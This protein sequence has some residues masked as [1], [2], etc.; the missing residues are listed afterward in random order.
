MN[1]KL[2]KDTLT[3]DRI[4]QIP[5]GYRAAETRKNHDYIG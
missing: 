4:D 1:Y 2:N 3:L 5:D